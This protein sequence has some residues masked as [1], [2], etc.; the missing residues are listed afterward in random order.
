MLSRFTFRI[1]FCSHLYMFYLDFVKNSEN[2]KTSKNLEVFRIFKKSNWI[3]SNRIIRIIRQ[4]SI[5]RKIRIFG[6]RINNCSQTR[7][8][9]FQFRLESIFQM[10]VDFHFTTWNLGF[11]NISEYLARYSI[12]MDPSKEGDNLERSLYW[13][14]CACWGCYPRLSGEGS[15]L[16]KKMLIMKR[17]PWRMSTIEHR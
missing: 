11:L 12:Q 15:H 7:S 6:Q 3:L 9:G 8:F 1:L 14:Y 10:N 16:I 13:Q 5:I 4:K 2:L 17:L